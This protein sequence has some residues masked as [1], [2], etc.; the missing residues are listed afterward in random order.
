MLSSSRYSCETLVSSTGTSGEPTFEEGLQWLSK[1][2]DFFSHA[3]QA[4]PCIAEQAS[5]VLQGIELQKK[6]ILEIQLSRQ[7]YRALLRL[8]HLL[9]ERRKAFAE[10]NQLHTHEHGEYIASYYI[11]IADGRS[12]R[13]AASF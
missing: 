10:A 6:S 11:G 7:E 8:P 5:S 9:P 3:H 2:H 1:E 4:L 12:R 13:S